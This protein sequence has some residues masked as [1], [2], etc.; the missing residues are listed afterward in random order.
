[1]WGSIVLSLLFWGFANE[2]TKVHEAK[3]F[4]AVFALGANCSGIFSGILVRYIKNIKHS[5]VLSYTADN[6]WI[7]YQFFTILL[8]SLMVIAVFFI[9]NKQVFS[10]THI[11]GSKV[12]ARQEKKTISLTECFKYLAS[13]RYLLYVVMIVVTYNIVYNLADVMWT[14]KVNQIYVT[15]ECLNAYTNQITSA[16]GIVAVVFAF[17]VSGNVIRRYGWTVAA[18]V[19]PVIWLVTS[20]GFF[21]GLLLDGSAFFGV[22]SAIVSN[23][24]NFV[25]FLGSMQIALGRGCKYTVFDETKEIV[26][27]PLSKESQRKGKAIVDGLASRFGK[28]GG[29]CIY[30]SLFMVCGGITNS[31]PYVACI[32]FLGIL[33]WIYAVLKLGDM[34]KSQVDNGAGSDIIAKDSE[35]KSVAT[36]SIKV[37]PVI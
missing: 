15:E 14:H 3:R 9:L 19:T 35:P 5:S 17:I 8:V 24:A 37:S 13:S 16:T 18:L 23:P 27:I 36:S 10:D 22:I 28:S 1:M 12:K 26:F 2:V 4:Y 29:S 6:Q 21:G 33:I 25:L 20:G 32:M 34:V 31:I 30:L 11:T 7:F